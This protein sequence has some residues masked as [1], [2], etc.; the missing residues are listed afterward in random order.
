MEKWVGWIVRK[1][2]GWQ[3]RGSSVIF[4]VN[5]ILLFAGEEPQFGKEHTTKHTTD[6]KRPVHQCQSNFFL[7]INRI[8]ILK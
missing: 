2:V 6:R 1:K 5:I 7:Q 4:F 8:V 3:K